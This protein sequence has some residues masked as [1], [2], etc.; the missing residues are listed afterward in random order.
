[1][2]FQRALDAGVLTANLSQALRVESIGARFRANTGV[3]DAD[4]SGF[5]QELVA[6]VAQESRDGARFRP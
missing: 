3:S 1:M 5:I 6:K 2:Q 4:L